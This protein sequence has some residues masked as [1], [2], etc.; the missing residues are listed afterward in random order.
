MNWRHGAVVQHEE[1]LM[2][3]ELKPSNVACDVR[4]AVCGQGF[5]LFS[6]RLAHLHHH[7]VQAHVQQELR[8]HHTHRNDHTAHPAESFSMPLLLE[9]LRP[10]A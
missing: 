10:A 5:L 9:S 7:K 2:Y 1:I 3:V 4:C 6:S 8:G